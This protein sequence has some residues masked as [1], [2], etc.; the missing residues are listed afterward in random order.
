M[1]SPQSPDASLLNARQAQACLDAAE[2]IRECYRVLEKPGL[3]IVGEILRG[4]GKFY[5]MDHYP[6]KDV[7][8]KEHDSQYYYHAHR[9]DHDEH[10]HFHLFVR[11]AAM[12]EALKPLDGPEGDDRVAHLI[13]VSMDAWGYPTEL[14]A[15]NRWVTDESWFKAES[16]ISL[17][18]R[19]CIDH[20]HPN[21]AVNRWLSAMV[22]CFRP[23]I[24]SL[25]LH[26]DQVIARWQEEKRQT[27]PEVLEDRDLEVTGTIVLDMKDWQKA[28]QKEQQRQL[29]GQAVN[30]SVQEQPEP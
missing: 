24:E 15:V 27:L 25:L 5:E 16:V 13:A 2:E 12:P 22:Q 6:K 17:L 3:N 7:Y 21:L 4:Q 29:A 10:G 28:L 11:H 9:R 19:F 26:R 18:D 23:H 14:F 20:A 1:L 30:R 8:D